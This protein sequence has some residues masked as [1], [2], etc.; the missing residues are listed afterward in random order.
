[1]AQ[2]SGLDDRNRIESAKFPPAY[3]RIRYDQERT[4]LNRQEVLCFS[5]DGK[6]SGD[7]GAKMA[8]IKVRELISWSHRA[9]TW[10]IIK[11]GKRQL[12]YILL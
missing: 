11:G 6:K 9:E 8:N 5:N 7:Q 3:Q 1:M 10:R 4:A 2:D 12:G